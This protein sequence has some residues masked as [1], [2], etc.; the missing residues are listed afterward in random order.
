MLLVWKVVWIVAMHEKK[1][2]SAL[3]I[4]LSSVYSSPASR[5]LTGHSPKIPSPPHRRS[6]YIAYQPLQLRYNLGANIPKPQPHYNPHPQQNLS[7]RRTARSASTFSLREF[8][9]GANSPDWYHPAQH[10]LNLQSEIRNTKVKQGHLQDMLD[11]NEVHLICVCC[12]AKFSILWCLRDD[13]A[14]VLE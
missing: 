10:N 6:P 1:R 14:C 2:L 11:W 9:K 4:H 12:C 3:L 7:Q 8:H 13:Y 5:T